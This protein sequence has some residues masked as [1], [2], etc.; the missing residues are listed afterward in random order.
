[1]TSKEALLVELYEGVTAEGVE[2]ARQMLSRD[3]PPLEAVRE[4]LIERIVYTCENRRLLQILFEEEAEIPA[5]LMRSMRRQRRAYEDSLIELLNRGAADGSISFET[6][7]ESLSTRCS[8]Q[9]TGRTS[10]TTQGR[11]ERSRAG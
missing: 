7:R 2:S 8:A 10:G 1:M 11:E 3:L 9:R 4:L 5:D 6:T